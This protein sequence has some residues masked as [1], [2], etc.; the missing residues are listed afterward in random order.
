[1]KNH[2]VEI[3]TKKV[4]VHLYQSLNLDDCC[5]D[6]H[7]GSIERQG[8]TV[9]MIDGHRLVA[10][11]KITLSMPPGYYLDLIPEIV[12]KLKK[13]LESKHPLPWKYFVGRVFLREDDFI[14]LVYGYG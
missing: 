12:K 7:S 9:E 14:D 6:F 10:G 2:A 3:L 8:D 11:N 5:V 4:I 13:E 1:M